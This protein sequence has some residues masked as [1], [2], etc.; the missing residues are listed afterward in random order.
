MRER[1]VDVAAVVGLAWTT[2]LNILFV[3]LQHFLFVISPACMC[4]SVVVCVCGCL[5]VLVNVVKLLTQ[6]AFRLCGSPTTHFWLPNIDANAGVNSGWCHAI[7]ESLICGVRF[8]LETE[9]RKSITF[10]NC[11]SGTMKLL[12]IFRVNMPFYHYRLTV[13]MC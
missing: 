9:I 4:D 13:P 12:L 10:I 1:L 2:C 5:N 7:C 8:L 11:Y 3:V 6:V